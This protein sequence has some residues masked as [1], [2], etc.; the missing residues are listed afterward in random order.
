MVEEK[1]MTLV[2]GSSGVGHKCVCIKCAE[3]LDNLP[4]KKRLCPVCREQFTNVKLCRTT[5]EY[6]KFIFE[7]TGR[8]LH[9][10]R[11]DSS[12]N[13]KHKRSEERVSL[14]LNNWVKSAAPEPSILSTTDE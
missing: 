9:L 14:Y 1:E 2:H 4:L 6:K 11:L 13:K 10:K 3:R 8:A 7:K 5:R 12:I